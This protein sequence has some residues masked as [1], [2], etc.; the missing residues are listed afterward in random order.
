VRVR[1][2]RRGVGREAARRPVLLETVRRVGDPGRH[3]FDAAPVDPGPLLG[4]R[5]RVGDLG[6]TGC[7]DQL[8]GARGL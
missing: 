5:H 6:L 4:R 7:L 2:A 3:A 8:L 1:V